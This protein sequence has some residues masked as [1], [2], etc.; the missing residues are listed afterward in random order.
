MELASGRIWSYW[1]DAYVHRLLAASAMGKTVDLGGGDGGDA[2]ANLS[3][4]ESLSFEFTLLLSQ[5]LDSQR[6][7][8]E[9]LLSGLFALCAPHRRGEA[10]SLLGLPEIVGEGAGPSS[11]KS[12]EAGSPKQVRFS[13]GK[14]HGGAGSGG[15]GSGGGGGGRNS[16]PPPETERSMTVLTTEVLLLREEVDF[17]RDMK[18]AAQHKAGYYEKALATA[19]A[20]AATAAAAA[21]ERIAELEETV[22]D[23]MISLDVGARVEGGEL[24]GGTV[25][26]HRS[27]GRAG[28][29]SAAAKARTAKRR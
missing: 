12:E 18:D 25:G 21:A 24:A 27:A 5:T 1:A 2:S 19:N 10:R 14:Q 7:H 29:A 17:L 4:I 22:R 23:L 8:Y 13:D 15:G 6:Q 28:D 3:K 26:V 11:S 16:R 9:E 20:A